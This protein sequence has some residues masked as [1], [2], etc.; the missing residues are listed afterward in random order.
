V[1]A[2][3]TI[4][5]V[6]YFCLLLLLSLDAAAQTA[7]ERA[8]RAD[9]R[10]LRR[11]GLVTAQE[12][13]ER[14]RPAVDYRLLL[15]VAFTDAE[16]GERRWATP[17][18]VRARFNERKTYLKVSGDGYVDSRLGDEHASGLANLNVGVG[19]RLA[20]GLRGFLGIT[21]P[22]GGEVGSERGR[23]RAG[24]SYERTLWGAWS[25][26]I[27]A[28]LVRYDADPDPGESRVRRQA[29]MQVAYS[30]DPSTLALIQFERIY[31]PGVSSA[32]V[33]SLGYQVAIAE[34]AAG[35]IFGVLMLS[36]GFTAG[37]HDTTI[38]F[39]VC[40]RF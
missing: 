21:I 11:D 3:P 36:R 19:H 9:A 14:A 4:K 37:A 23:E 7:P 17:F 32:S 12:F 8:E 18:Q 28:Q 25:G 1:G 29:L 6:R 5:V 26:L 40:L 35:P 24:L 34:N 30:F 39:D 31:R 13:A 22:T 27:E 10:E 33:M 38:E 16:S 2:C 15:G 20:E